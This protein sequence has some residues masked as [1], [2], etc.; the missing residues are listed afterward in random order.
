LAVVNLASNGGHIARYV[1][2]KETQHIEEKIF[3]YNFFLSWLKLMGEQ[4]IISIQQLSVDRTETP[5]VV[6]LIL[7]LS[8]K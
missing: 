3:P 4:Y 1:R 2:S 5:G 8:V 7:L 6:K